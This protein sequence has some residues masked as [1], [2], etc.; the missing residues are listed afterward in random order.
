MASPTIAAFSPMLLPASIVGR[1]RSL[2]GVGLGG[3]AR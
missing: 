3:A 2:A 1:L